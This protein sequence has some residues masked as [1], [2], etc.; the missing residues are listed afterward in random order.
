[1]KYRNIKWILFLVFISSTTFTFSQ[2]IPLKVGEKVPATLREYLL[3]TTA[4]SGRPININN[5]LIIDFWATWC[6][7]CVAKLPLLDSLQ[8]QYKEKLNIISVTEENDALVKEVLDKVFKGET[9]NLNIL[10][11]EKQLK[12]YFPHSTIPHYVWINREGVI[13]AISQEVERTDV[14]GFINQQQLSTDMKP[15]IINYDFKRPLYASKQAEV[16]DGLLYHSMITKYTPDLSTFASRGKNYIS[17]S[18]SSIVNLFQLAY[19]KFNLQYWDWNRIKVTGLT[20]A[21]DSASIGL[22]PNARLKAMYKREANDFLYELVFPDSISNDKL[23]EFMQNDLNRYFGLQ[24]IEAHMEKKRSKVL[25]LIYIDS[26]RK[27]ALNS[28][29]QPLNYTTKTSLKVINMS[30]PFF[31]SQ[32]RPMLKDIHIPL[33]NGTKY[34]GKVSIELNGDFSNIKEINEQMKKY[35]LQLKEVNEDIDI[36][37]I[38]KKT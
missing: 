3:Q 8:V 14:E 34:N 33:K 10:T 9:I 4:K 16:K 28:N 35:G 29:E 27:R 12:Q 24:G 32:L 21:L 2:I 19:G 22:W 17:V 18:N 30:M 13:K 5:A 6:S 26:S 7:P 25:S 38:N 31:I 37:V 15:A 11:N 1:M 20:S 36:I 23:F